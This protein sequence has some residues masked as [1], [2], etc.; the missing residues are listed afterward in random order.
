[1]THYDTLGVA[2]N[3][4]PQE[5]KTAFRRLAKQHHPDSGGDVSKFQKIS[6]A[7]EI[8]SDTDKRAHYD[9]QITHGNRHSNFEWNFNANQTPNDIFGD[10]NEQFSQMFGFNFRHAQTPRNRNIRLQLNLDFLETLD[11]IQKT[12]EYNITNGKELITLDIQAGIQ[13]NTL[14]QIQGRGDNANPAVPRGNLEVLIKVKTHAKFTK[15]E[16]HILTEV[17]IDCFQ[18]MLGCEVELETPRGKNIN[19]RRPAGTQNGTQ[20]GINDQGFS[21]SNK[22]IGKLIVKINVLIP[23]VL[24]NEQINLVQQIQ[25]MRPINT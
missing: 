17:T 24:T 16:D 11:S 8:L 15:I 25:A 4:T 10:I 19:L 2:K 1:M 23:S 22:S 21:R 14:I 6:E 18:A 12:L 13:D 3:V 5:I 9:H 20:M 7:Y